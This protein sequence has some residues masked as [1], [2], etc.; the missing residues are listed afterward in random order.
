MEHGEPLHDHQTLN[1][2][3]PLMNL[4]HGETRAGD[5]SGDSSERASSDSQVT[6][7]LL[8]VSGFCGF[9]FW[10][11]VPM[12]NLSP[13]WHFNKHDPLLCPQWSEVGQHYGDSSTFCCFSLAM[14]EQCLRGEELRARH[15][16]ALFKL[17]KKALREKARA[18]LAWLGHQKR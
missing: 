16:A 15:Q 5:D 4:P 18:E 10:L 12:S 17:R 9:F 13:T 3:S 2:L 1:L 8:P 6:P 7:A 11:L 14:V